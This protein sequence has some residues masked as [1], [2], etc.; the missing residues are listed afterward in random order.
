LLSAKD[1]TLVFIDEI[2]EVPEAF[3]ILRY[4][5]ESYLEIAVIV[6]GSM[7]ETLFKKNSSFPV[8]RVEYNVVRP[9]SFPEFLEAAG[10]IQ[11]LQQFT[12]IPL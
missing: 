3:N 11:A 10:E 9:V 1:K 2:Q 12:H 8:G 5:Y 6:A 4:F 7:L